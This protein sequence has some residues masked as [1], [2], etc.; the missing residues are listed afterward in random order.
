MLEIT[1]IFWPMYE[2]KNEST[3]TPSG[4]VTGKRY[5]ICVFTVCQSTHLRV[6][7]TQ[8]VNENK[9]ITCTLNLSPCES[10]DHLCINPIPPIGLIHKL[11]ID[12]KSPITL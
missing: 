1:D 9:T 5:F 12:Y 6:F 10:I 11:S 8:R 2:E 4:H 3:P 7:S